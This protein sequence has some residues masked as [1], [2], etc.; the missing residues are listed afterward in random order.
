[1]L[2]LTRP[3]NSNARHMHVDNFA[4]VVRAIIYY[5]NFVF[6][7]SSLLRTMS[8]GTAGF[9]IHDFLLV[10]NSNT[11]PNFI[12]VWVTE[13]KNMSGPELLKR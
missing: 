4:M 2:C 3:Q 1:M 8:D 12:P 6:Y 5:Y 7:L 10:V 11:C 13:I 9:H